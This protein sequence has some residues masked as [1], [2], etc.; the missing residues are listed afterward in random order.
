MV[1]KLKRDLVIFSHLI[2][3]FYVNNAQDMSK[4]IFWEN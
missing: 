3:M 2:S 1:R 4:Y